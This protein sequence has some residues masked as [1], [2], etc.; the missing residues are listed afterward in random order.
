MAQ[1]RDKDYVLGTHDAELERLGLQHQVWRASVISFW[2]RAG[3]TRGK[4]VIDAGAGP[5]FATTDLAEIVGREGRVIAIERSERFL[6]FLRDEA[7]RRLLPQAETIEGDLLEVAWPQGVADFIWCRW[8]LAFVAD[9]SLV[10]T[11]MA[12][13][14]KPGGAVLIHEYVDYSSWSLLPSLPE[15]DR[16]VELVV[17]TW[18]SSGGEPDIARDLPRLLPKAGLVLES[19]QA[20]QFAITARD[21]M[22]HWPLSFIDVNT[23]HH[24][25]LGN[26]SAKEAKEMRAAIHARL[27]E[28]GALMLTPSVL[29]TVARKPA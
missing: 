29:Q 26:L 3:L 4:T 11:R 20:V 2:Q 6:R 25:E 8:V 22:W 7:A 17:R 23:A 9:P 13:A 16:F 27:S 24:V 5:G 10:L 28:P 18:R 12:R 14:L 1:S 19:A 15:M 21:F